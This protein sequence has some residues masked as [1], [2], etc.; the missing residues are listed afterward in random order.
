MLI[1]I[2]ADTH[3]RLPLIDKAVERMNRE[4]VDLVI[5]A[6]DY[7]AP[8]VVQHF[9]PLKAKLIGVFGNNDGELRLLK[10]KFSEIGHEIRGR[11]A[12]VI[13]D[14]LRMAILHGDDE[15]LLN[16]LIN[17]GG[18]N[19]VIHGHTH[20]SMIRRVGKTLVINPGEVCGYLT[21]KSTIAKLD[22]EKLQVEVIT[23]K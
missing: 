10:E 7:I 2:M 15:E 5:H 16:S 13:V 19:V 4:K 20:Q 8:F 21:A 14:G 17:C 9:K 12:E 18:Y 23:L 11:F 3:D 6:G 1:G 22:T